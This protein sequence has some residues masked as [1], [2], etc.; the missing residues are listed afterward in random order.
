MRPLLYLTGPMIRTLMRR[1]HLTV[2]PLA[3]RQAIPMTRVR[4]RRQQ[5][6]VDPQVA[7]WRA[8][9]RQW[10]AFAPG[11]VGSLQGVLC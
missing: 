1:H 4:V 6:E 9:C 5:G 7:R 8:P 11:W 10:R 3:K 2:R